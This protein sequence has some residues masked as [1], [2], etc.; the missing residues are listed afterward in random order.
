[1]DTIK[2]LWLAEPARVAGYVAALIVFLAA[3]F[4]VVVDE[5]SVVAAILYVVPI[6]IGTESTRAKVTPVQPALGRANDDLLHEQG[7]IESIDR[8]VADEQ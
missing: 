2:A 7:A 8:A 5:Q 4:G 6:I 1:M 3:S